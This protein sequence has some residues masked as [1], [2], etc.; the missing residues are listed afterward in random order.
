MQLF[1]SYTCPFPENSALLGLETTIHHTSALKFYPCAKK[2]EPY[3]LFI[4][5]RMRSLVG[6]VNTPF[7]Q[8][9]LY[10]STVWVKSRSSKTPPLIAHKSRRTPSSTQ[11]SNQ[12]R[13]QF[14]NQTP[15][16]WLKKYKIENK[17]LLYGTVTY[18]TALLLHIVAI[19][20]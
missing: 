14:Q 7:V 16:G 4:P 3:L 19:H 9:P 11:C 6:C 2:M 17:I 15:I 20:I 5:V 10:K 13:W 8:G 12:I 18:V 1:I